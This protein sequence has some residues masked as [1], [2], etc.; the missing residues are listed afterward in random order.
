MPQQVLDIINAPVVTEDDYA[1]LEGVLEIDDNNS[2]APENIPTPGGEQTRGIMN[3]DWGHNGVCFR[4]MEQIKN[5]SAQLKL[6][7]NDVPTKLD[8]FETLLPKDYIIDV[9]LKETNKYI[10]GEPV[11][12]GEFLVW[13]GLWFLMATCQGQTRMEFW[14]KKSIDMYSGAPHRFNDIMSSTRFRQIITKLK[15]F[16]RCFELIFKS[17]NKSLISVLIFSEKSIIRLSSAI[18]A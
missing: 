18:C 12:Y 5:Q 13:L 1:T 4:R 2:P 3:E 6:P 17:S 10:D 15:P 11:Q 14:S 7:M 9:V 16:V 8:L